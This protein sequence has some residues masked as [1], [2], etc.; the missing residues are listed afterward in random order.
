[1]HFYFFEQVDLVYS[2]FIG[3]GIGIRLYLQRIAT[4]GTRE[5][6]TLFA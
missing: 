5:S 1:M 4:M 6:M 3:I 2:A